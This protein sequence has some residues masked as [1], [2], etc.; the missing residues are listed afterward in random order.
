MKSSQQSGNLSAK[1]LTAKAPAKVILSGEHSVVYGSPALALAVNKFAFTSIK[2]SAKTSLFFHFKNLNKTIGLNFDQLTEILKNP[3]NKEQL[4]TSTDLLIYAF[5]YFVDYF[6]I[7]LTNGVEVII[8]SMIPIQCGMGSSAATIISLLHAVCKYFDISVNISEYVSIARQVENLQHG[9]SSGLDLFMSTNGGVYFYENGN[10]EKRTFPNMK[11][12]LVNS[13]RSESTTGECVASVAKM[14][15][16]SAIKD[17][18]TEVTTVMDLALQ[19]NNS[20]ALLNCI[21]EN[22]RILKYI[23]V[24]PEKVTEFIAEVEMLGGAAKISGAGAI[25]GNNAG[26]II[27]M[28]DEDISLLVKKFNYELIDVKTEPHGVILT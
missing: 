24:V 21:K 28:C 27:V 26:I 15:H 11:Y 18:F 23:G 5:V 14:F 1:S 2:S 7:T 16:D 20:Y 22:H 13:G 12:L 19:E 8:D 4:S 3:I 6:G 10:F 25:R 17:D 9:N